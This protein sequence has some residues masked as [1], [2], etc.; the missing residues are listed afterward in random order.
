MKK[1]KKIIAGN[2][3]AYHDFFIL[4]KYEAGIELKGTEVKAIKLQGCI[5]NDSFGRI[6]K[7]EAFILNMH[8]PPYTHG[9][10]YNQEPMRDRKLLLHKRE[11]SKI[12]DKVGQKGVSI[13]P[14]NVYLK[15]G[16]V[17]IEIG[18]C[19]GKKLYDKREDLK[20]KNQKREMD[21][22]LRNKV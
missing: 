4:E 22:V 13:I 21:R 2:K 1:N 17:K 15:N 12:F 18:I 6:V 9:N 14:L 11:I 8:I 10:I 20:K 16:K 19:Q 5:I 7:D 3:K